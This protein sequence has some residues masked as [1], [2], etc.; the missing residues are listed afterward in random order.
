MPAKQ[1]H[2][3]N[4]DIT[5]VNKNDP[6]PK[7][8]R[9]RNSCISTDDDWDAGIRW[10]TQG[11][12]DTY[13]FAKHFPHTCE[14]LS[15]GIIDPRRVAHELQGVYRIPTFPWQDKQISTHPATFLAH[16]TTLQA[17]PPKTCF[18]S[19]QR[20]Q[21]F[22]QGFQKDLS[23]LV[24]QKISRG[25]QEDDDPTN[26]HEEEGDERSLREQFSTILQD[27][28]DQICQTWAKRLDKE[29]FQNKRKKFLKQCPLYQGQP[30]QLDTEGKPI[31]LFF[32]HLPDPK[33]LENNM[34]KVRNR[35]SCLQNAVLNVS[36]G[37]HLPI[38]QLCWEC[39]S[40]C[41]NCMLCNQCKVAQYCGRACQVKA[42]KGGHKQMCT[43]LKKQ[44]GIF[45][46]S[47]KVVDD[48]YADGMTPIIQGITL[49]EEID[50]SV[51]TNMFT[52]N[53]PVLDSVDRSMQ[54]YY[55]NLE[56]VFVGDFWFCNSELILV[57]QDYNNRWGS[58]HAAEKQLYFFLLGLLSHDY[59]GKINRAVN[60]PDLEG[61]LDEA[62]ESQLREAEKQAYQEMIQA[63]WFS[64]FITDIGAEFGCPM[65]SRR[66][67]DLC[68]SNPSKQTH[69]QV[70]RH[71]LRREAR[72]KIIHELMG[73]YHK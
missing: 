7:F 41:P 69:D 49:S 13:G 73:Q 24:L 3:D 15:S 17:L 4:N 1:Q 40:V 62:A 35:I 51:L 27:S 60:R 18:R 11:R 26:P 45:Q 28:I 44:H 65:T 61:A 38:D 54:A 9:G 10:M 71:R 19:P 21:H 53:G 31:Y 50:Y 55:D 25:E 59:Y 34:S 68:I 33:W 22:V 37:M 66:F 48:K 70:D 23:D 46:T 42:W 39:Q 5:I 14:L 52:R 32:E 2:Q 72:Y 8:I 12:V 43:E 30:E 20:Y 6:P 36:K 16:L 57:E 67:I 47:L 64:N 29:L 63:R 56:R 58:K